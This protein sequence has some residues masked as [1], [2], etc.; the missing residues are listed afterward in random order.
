MAAGTAATDQTI[1][2]GGVPSP[3]SATP[4]SGGSGSFAFN[5][6]QFTPTAWVDIP[7]A[8]SMTY[9]PGPLTATTLFRQK[10]VDLL[11]G[12]N[13]PVT[14]FTNEVSINV[15][16]TLLPGTASASQDICYNT[17]PALLSATPPTGGFA[18]YSFLWQSSTNNTVFSDI[19]GATSLTYQPGALTASTWFRVAQTSSGSCGTVFTNALKIT[20]APQL[21][22]GTAGPSQTIC[23]NTAPELLTGTPPTGGMTPYTYIWRISYNG[24]IFQD[25]PGATDLTY[26]P[27]VLTTTT[28]YKLRQFSAGGCG[29]VTSAAVTITVLPP[30]NS[31]TAS[32]SQTICYNFIPALITATPPSGGSAPY[33]YQWQQSPDGQL[34][35]D[36]LGATGAAYQPPALLS[37]TLFRCKQISA[38]QCE[39]VFTNPITITV[40]PQLIPGNAAADQFLCPG[41][42]PD[43]I[44]ATPPAGGVTPYAYQ[45]QNSA[46]NLVFSDIPGASTLTWLPSFTPGTTYYRQKQTSSGNCGHVFTN[47]VNISIAEP[48]IPGTIASDQQIC[49]NSIPSQLYSTLPSGGLSPYLY[50]WQQS[51]DGVV[52]NDI[53]GA[54]NTS[55]QPGPLSSTTHY[56]L[57]QYSSYGCGSGFTNIIVVTVAAPFTA[58]AASMDQDI[59]YNTAPAL[60]S[61]TPPT[62]GFNPYSY[63]WQSS[64]DNTVFSDIPGESSLTYQPGT[65]TATTWYRLSQTSSGGC[66]IVYTDTLKI[67]VAPQLVSG[68]AGPSQT[69]CYNTAPALLTG[70]PPTGGM[71]PYTYLWRISYNG[72]IFQ[73]IPGATD[74]TYQP[75]VL[76]TTTW[77]K[78]RQFSAGGCGHVTSAAVMIRV[79][80]QFTAGTISSAQTICAGTAPVLLTGTPPAGGN[81]PYGFQWQQSADGLNF[82]IIPN[83]TE[84]NYQPGI[85][86]ADTWYRLEQQSSSGCG[87]VTTNVLKITVN[88]TPAPVITSVSD[89]RDTVCPYSGGHTYSTITGMTSYVWLPGGPAGT[90]IE[91]GQGTSQV[92]LFWGGPGPATGTLQVAATNQYGC[93]GTS[94]QKQIKI[95]SP[96]VAGTVAASQT[97]EYATIPAPVTCTTPSGGLDPYTYQWQQSTDGNNFTDISGATNLSY[98]PGILFIS[99]WYRMIQQSTG[100]CDPAT[101]NAI[102]ITVNPPYVKV[103]SPVGGEEWLQG[104][105]HSITWNDNIPDN[106]SI[107]LLKGGVVLENLASSVASSGSWIWNIPMNQTPGSDY[108]IRITSVASSAV[109]DQSDG[110]FTIVSRVPVERTIQNLVIFNGQDTCFDAL[111]TIYVAGGG[112]FFTVQPG[113]SAT[114]IAGQKILYRTGTRVFAGGY[115]HGYITTSNLYCGSLPPAMVAT[116]T[117]AETSREKEGPAI[118]VYPNPNAGS[119]TLQFNRA[120]ISGAEVDWSI[121]NLHGKVVLKGKLDDSGSYRI[122]METLPSGIYLLRVKWNDGQQTLKIIR[123]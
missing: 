65:L 123:N 26:Q 96:L 25:I 50:Q 8:T 66:G 97:I 114:M 64:T 80:D 30:F 108:R 93:T 104:S 79:Y 39:P 35:Q 33:G 117:A 81:S 18:P 73:D 45:W 47:S 62:G 11:C 122:S 41:E 119:F 112:S 76:T 101:T 7:G 63:L 52:F 57:D 118:R 102:K 40:I 49:F 48:F 92:S 109:T 90:I 37:T 23:Y 84:L 12:G 91:S 70:T 15:A 121:L 99:T 36:I 13:Q 86:F 24:S 78:L 10:Q 29:H 120:G 105:T 58:G 106:V 74:L 56:R 71:T 54:T 2:H 55:Y 1:C 82:S 31:G 95:T 115:M 9:A 43:T 61:A 75:G 87:T 16:D 85:L 20:V 46:N 53:P 38:F 51:A 116:V 21:V 103:T 17:V 4:P 83:A 5:W 72:S 44:T 88:P 111:Q 98:A 27:G 68:T 107:D 6:Q 67:T 42:Y 19:P 60:L 77:Y 59:C 22:V 3:L 32:S 110:D 34:Y 28:W 100:G 89:P 94:V 14:V 113:G 69:I